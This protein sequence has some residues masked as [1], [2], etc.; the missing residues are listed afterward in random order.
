MS[1]TPSTP[2]HSVTA[3]GA[4]VTSTMTPE[5]RFEA[6]AKALNAHVAKPQPVTF[7]GPKG[8]PHVI[9]DTPQTVQEMVGADPGTIGGK[10]APP[11]PKA[12]EK[13]NAMPPQG[14]PSPARTGEFND[15][16][17]A[18]GLMRRTD[19]RTI[20]A[21][22]FD[23]EAFDL[24][25]AKY[26]LLAAGAKGHPEIQQRWAKKYEDDVKALHD[27]LQLTGEQIAALRKQV[28]DVN[29]DSFVPQTKAEKELDKLADK[30]W[31]TP[32]PNALHRTLTADG[33]K[34]EKALLTE[35]RA[36]PESERNDP[37][38]RD[39]YNVALATIR[40]NEHGMVH[41]SAFNASMLHG[42]K[43]PDFLGKAHGGM[44]YPAKIIYALAE[45]RRLGVTQQQLE[46]EIRD[47]LVKDGWLSTRDRMRSIAADSGGLLLTRAP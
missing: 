16:M 41:V 31:S 18:K 44:H 22:D 24:L 15:E 39:D 5:A 25:T 10:A 42:Y 38:T 2:V 21:D 40:Q 12:L 4:T 9:A 7:S 6:I 8:H 3:H 36:L 27:G 1:E 37:Q 33:Q 47:N 30:E 23:Q 46:R 17:R 20:A 32:T 14:D 29:A 35:F 11:S 43:L 26:K 13:Q 34:F 19:G 28:G 45:A